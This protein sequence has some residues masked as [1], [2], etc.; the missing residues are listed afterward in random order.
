MRRDGNLVR[1]PGGQRHL[2]RNTNPGRPFSRRALRQLYSELEQS[3]LLY[4]QRHRAERDQITRRI[5]EL[6]RGEMRSESETDRTTSATD[7]LRKAQ[8]GLEK[9]CAGIGLIFDRQ[10]RPGL[11]SLLTQTQ[12]RKTKAR[13]REAGRQQD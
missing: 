9:V 11:V 1:M 10:L 3:L 8:H 13:I 4:E 2:S 6:Q 5:D 12:I 7:E